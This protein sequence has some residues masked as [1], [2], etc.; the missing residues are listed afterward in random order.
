MMNDPYIFRLSVEMPN[1]E[2]V[3][4]AFNVAAHVARE[5]KWSRYDLCSDAVTATLVGGV[6]ALGAKRI[7]AEREKLAAEV[8]RELT[9]HILDAIKSR[10]L[11]DGVSAAE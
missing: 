5:F 8:S 2:R 11:R 7:D 1:G 9:R 6:D 3:V 10:D 4:S